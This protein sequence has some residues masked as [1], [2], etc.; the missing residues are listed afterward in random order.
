MD[1]WTYIRKSIKGN[2]IEF[3]QELD[4]EYWGDKIG[5]SYDD[6]LN[7]KWINLSNAQISFHRRN[8]QASIREVL[9]MS[10][11]SIPEPTLQEVLQEKLLQ[12]QNY[13]NSEAVN[14]FFVQ[15]DDKSIRMW[16]NATE[17]SNYKNSLDSA[18]MLNIETV[19]VPVNGQLINIS[20]QKARLFLAQI[21]VY[22]DTC[23]LVT[24]SHKNNI[25]ALN[26]I[27]EINQYDYT[28]GYPEK[29]TFNINE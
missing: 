16:Y 2:Y 7:N 22:A 29:L 1:K 11:D 23:A 12:L 18:S 5:Y 9:S 28:T 21:Q 24:L 25:S 14:S 20:L 4:P 8:P 15:N 27:E 26:S 19:N 10:L 6:Y 3:D 13:D 17:R